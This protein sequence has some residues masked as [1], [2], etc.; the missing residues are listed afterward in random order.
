[1]INASEAAENSLGE[2]IEYNKFHWHRRTHR[3]AKVNKLEYKK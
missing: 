1:M 2:I 3:L